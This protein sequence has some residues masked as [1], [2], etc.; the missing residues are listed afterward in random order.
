MKNIN[1]KQSKPEASNFDLLKGVGYVLAAFI[2]AVGFVYA[3]GFLG[4]AC[5]TILNTIK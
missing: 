3:L 5:E 2:C 1:F 4:W